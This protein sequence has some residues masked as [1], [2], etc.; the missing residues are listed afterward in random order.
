MKLKVVEIFC[1]PD[2]EVHG[3]QPPTHN[4]TSKDAVLFLRLLFCPVPAFTAAIP[5]VNRM[6]ILVMSLSE[7][8]SLPCQERGALLQN[9]CGYTAP[10]S[11]FALERQ[12]VQG[13]RVRGGLCNWVG[14]VLWSHQLPMWPQTG[15][16]TTLCFTLYNFRTG[17]IRIT[18]T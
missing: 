10:L 16:L 12:H 1:L 17:I 14:L 3:Q 18:T 9:P 7:N 13:S 11:A 4:T 6:H 8:F 15:A 5:R 2:P